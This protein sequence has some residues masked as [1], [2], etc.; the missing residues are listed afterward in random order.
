MGEFCR[1]ATVSRPDICARSA[2][3]PSRVHAQQGPDIYRI[4]G[5]VRT[6]K[7]WQTATISKYASP[8]RQKELK[9]GAVD[10]EKRIRGERDHCA[11]MSL[12]GRSNAADGDQ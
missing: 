12:F 1:L 11:T 8:S 10:G 3:L 2:R 4:N 7:E 6:E 5:L 9:D